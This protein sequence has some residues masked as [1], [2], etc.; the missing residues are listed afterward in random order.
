LKSAI[1]LIS[2]SQSNLFGLFQNC[3]ATLDRRE[4]CTV[5]PAIIDPLL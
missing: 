2:N 3:P 1:T 5:A 4:R